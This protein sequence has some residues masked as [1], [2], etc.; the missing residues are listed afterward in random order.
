MSYFIAEV[1]GSNPVGA[2]DFFLGFICNC[3]SYS[4]TARITFT[5]IL[6]PQCTRM[7]FIIYT[8]CLIFVYMSVIFI[9]FCPLNTQDKFVGR[10]GAVHWEIGGQHNGSD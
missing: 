5:C 1:M 3:L 6:Y 2:S 9:C 10:A 7:I 8:S 4:I